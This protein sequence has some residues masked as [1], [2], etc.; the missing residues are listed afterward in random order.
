MTDRCRPVT[1]IY[2]MIN[3]S[4]APARHEADEVIRILLVDDHVIFRAAMRAVL[5]MEA[6]M[7]VV[8][9]ASN[10]IEALEMVKRHEPHVVIMD[11]EMPGGHGTVATVAISRLANPPFVIVLT[12]HSEEE[13]LVALLTSGAS[14]FLSK[15]AQPEELLRAI[16]VVA[17]G[18]MYVRQR[19]AS[20]LAARIHSPAR[21]S[22]LEVARSKIGRL[23]DREREVLVQIARG[24]NGP[25]IGTRIGISPKTVET[26]KRRIAEKIGLAHRAEYVSFALTTGL[27]AAP[28][29]DGI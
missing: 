22:S 5:S 24:Y 3:C 7:L 8:G 6:D 27:M 21:I 10:G 19:A 28:D 11:L 17:G 1:R 26:Y 9:E 13:S 14:G 16:R 20:I 15:D 29:H 18:E 23:S 2:A 4:I 25:E 12:M